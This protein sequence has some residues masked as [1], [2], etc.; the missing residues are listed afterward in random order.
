MTAPTLR[1]LVAE[2]EPHLG[3]LVEECLRGRGLEVVLVR[4]GGEAAARLA[5]ERYDVA[6]LDVQMPVADGLVVLD[7][8][9]ALADPPEVIVVTG[10][11]A[12]HAAVEALRRGAY[13]HVAK[14]YRMAEVELVVRRAGEKR[15]LRAEVAALRAELRALRGGGAASPDAGGRSGGPAGGDDGG[16]EGASHAVQPGPPTG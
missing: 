8:A 11:A 5:A 10:N 3:V 16:S 2:D 7:G 15:A 4:D 14:P 1:V 12:G 13:A 6:L 9:R